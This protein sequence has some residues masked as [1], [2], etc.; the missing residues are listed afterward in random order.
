MPLCLSAYCV[1]SITFFTFSLCVS[2]KSTSNNRKWAEVYFQPVI[3]YLLFNVGDIF[4]RQMAGWIV[5]PLR[6]P[7]LNILV[8]LRIL[9]IPLFL[10]CNTD[11]E[12]IPNYF[13]HD[14]VY[15]T[16][17][18]LFSISNGY[19]SAMCHMLAPKI[20]AAEDAEKARMI[21][22]STHGL[23]I[24]IGCVFTFI[25]GGIPNLLVT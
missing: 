9:F 7:L 15:I 5:R 2:V 4:G 1:S 19:T 6:G 12:V 21:M 23:G 18:L 16:L 17:V 13:T 22:A 24:L 14:A 20:V 25:T 10:L 11:S 8:L 3:T